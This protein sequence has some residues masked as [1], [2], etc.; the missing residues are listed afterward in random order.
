[1]KRIR[2]KIIIILLAMV[3]IPVIPTSILVYNLVNRS[4]QMGVNS[5]VQQALK[6]GVSFSKE[7]YKNVRKQLSQD[8][9]DLSRSNVHSL[10]K[11]ILGRESL[12]K[13]GFDSSFWD[14]Y[15]I[16]FVDKEGHIFWEKSFQPEYK[17][18]LDKRI[19]HQFSTPAQN[20]LVVSDRENNHFTAVQ[21]V[22]IDGQVSGFLVMEAGLQKAYIDQSDHLL[23]VHQIFQTLDVSRSALLRSFLYT[24]IAITLVLLSVVVLFG[25]WISSRITAPISLLVK[26][27][28]EI[29]KGNLD[30]H[31]PPLK[32][33][34]ELG[35]LVE[36]FNQMAQQLKINQERVIYLEKMTAWQQ[37][38]RK[39]AHEVKNPLTPIQ[40][41]V[42]QLVDKYG[43]ESDDYGQLLKECAGI[44]NEEIGS[45]RQLVTEFSEFGKLPELKLETNDLNKLIRE[46]SS[47]YSDRLDLK[48]D[49]DVPQFS[50]DSD[51]IRR[52]ILNLIE[53]SIQA[54]PRNQQIQVQTVIANK[55]VILI[56]QDKGKGIPK[57]ELEKIFEPYFSTKS[58]G[59]GLGLAISRLIIEEHHGKI[60]VDSKI[61]EGTIFTV[62]FP[63]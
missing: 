59:T 12:F 37:M 53:N 45:L 4:Y 26:G 18:A 20:G 35:R 33:N 6:E 8:L 57:E 5:Q 60:S 11:I 41:T 7:I 58:G 15:S 38:A 48:L 46:I 27:T 17:K 51:R 39:I 3:I 22:M 55:K 49:K 29:G 16:S 28:G 42:Q 50:F 9:S 32:R 1:M 30:Y 63:L 24:F 34:D 56:I 44:I 25:M 62:H 47:L 52:V 23:Q 54:D 31:L 21:K 36:H 19:L 2:S 61:G 43:G 13:L 40:L 10:E 14:I